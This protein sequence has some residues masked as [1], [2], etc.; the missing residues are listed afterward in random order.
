MI[1]IINVILRSIHE[2][3]LFKRTLNVG[4]KKRE[5]KV[6]KSKNKISHRFI[7]S[8][9]KKQLQKKNFMT[10]LKK[11]FVKGDLHKNH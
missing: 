6:F 4:K 8:I 11:N 2:V 3:S 1:M 5:E 9:E 10:M 7:N